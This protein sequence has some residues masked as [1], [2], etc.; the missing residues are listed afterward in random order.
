MVAW[1]FLFT[2]LAINYSMAKK[3]A[4]ADRN[5]YNAR[6]SIL[7]NLVARLKA[8]EQ[9]SSSE[10]DQQ[11]RLAWGVGGMGDGTGMDTQNRVAWSEVLFG[12]RKS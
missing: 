5:Q 11:R 10:I 7:E 4:T 12:Q 9:I 3:Q 8:G 1:A 6:I 2:S